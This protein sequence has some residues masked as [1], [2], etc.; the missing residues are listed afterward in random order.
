[1]FSELDLPLGGGQ[2]GAHLLKT[3]PPF[4]KDDLH[5]FQRRWV[6]HLTRTWVAHL[7]RLLT[8][9]HGTF[10]VTTL[11]TS[12]RPRT[13]GDCFES[14]LEEVTGWSVPGSEEDP[15]C[16]FCLITRSTLNIRNAR[17]NSLWLDHLE[18]RVARTAFNA[19]STF[20]PER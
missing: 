13:P 19:H 17:R 11:A 10:R 9:V 1:M 7:G 18:E 20:S 3:L 12:E 14:S 2:V 16:S 8:V 5:P 6:A 15:W 4:S